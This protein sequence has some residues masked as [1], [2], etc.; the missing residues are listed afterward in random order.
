MEAKE[1]GKLLP[2]PMCGSKDVHIG[3]TDDYYPTRYA[4]TCHNCW[5]STDWYGDEE[6]AE[7]QWNLRTG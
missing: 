3:M 5:L 6:K 4:G 1:Q 2:C 7:Q